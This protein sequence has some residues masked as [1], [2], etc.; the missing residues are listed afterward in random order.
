MVLHSADGWLPHLQYEQAEPFREIYRHASRQQ[1]LDL[2]DAR[3]RL[4]LSD[5]FDEVCRPALSKAFVEDDRPD[6]VARLD[7]PKFTMID[8]VDL[9]TSEHEYAEPFDGMKAEI[10]EAENSIRRGKPI[11][12]KEV[13][14][15]LMFALSYHFEWL[16]AEDVL[17][18][19]RKVVPFLM[20]VIAAMPLESASHCWLFTM[21]GAWNCCRGV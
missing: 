9:M 18:Y 12:W 1:M 6:V 14:D 11:R 3:G 5:Y 19:R 7:D 8:F 16:Y 4:S 10:P 2:R 13:L 17:T 21:R 20:N 15:D